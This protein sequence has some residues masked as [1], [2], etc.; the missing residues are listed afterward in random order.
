[1]YV[2]MLKS[3][4]NHLE[5]ECVPEKIKPVLVGMKEKIEKQQKEIEDLK[6]LLKEKANVVE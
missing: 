3:M 4:K 6:A 1:M 5:N 2:G